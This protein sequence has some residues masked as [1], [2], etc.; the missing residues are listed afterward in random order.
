ME[1]LNNYNQQKKNPIQEEIGQHVHSIGRWNTFFGVLAVIGTVF[2]VLG[3]LFFIIMGI[4]AL[5]AGAFSSGIADA[6]SERGYESWM[7]L[8]MGIVYLIG[9][10]LNIPI[11]IFLFRAGKAAREAVECRNDK[12]ALEFISNTHKYWRFYGIVTIVMYALCLVAIP[13]III[14]A[15]VSV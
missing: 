8:P 12:V 10:G 5:M 14:A 3:G 7:I 6:F 4:V 1:E 13:I 9:A 2:M 15:A 11:A